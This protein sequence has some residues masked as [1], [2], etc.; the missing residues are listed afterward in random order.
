MKRWRWL[1]VPAVA[2]ALL[3]AGMIYLMESVWVRE[4]VRTLIVTEVEKAT[5]GKLSLIHI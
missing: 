4:K 1:L 2:V 3:A 5:G